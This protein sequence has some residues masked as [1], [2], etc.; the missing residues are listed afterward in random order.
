MSARVA[1][2]GS[3]VKRPDHATELLRVAALIAQASDSVS[4]VEQAVLSQIAEATGL[5][6]GD[7]ASAIEDAEE[8]LSA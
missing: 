7:V 8:A 1:V 3:I 5:G 6:P 4:E 2:L